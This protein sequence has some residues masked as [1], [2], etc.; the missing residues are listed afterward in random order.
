MRA[1]ASTE[2][3]RATETTYV[4]TQTAVQP[5]TP[6]QIC[7]DGMLSVARAAEFLGLGQTSIYRLMERGD[8]RWAN[9]LVRLRIPKR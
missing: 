6:E 4:K 9:V 2:P 8:L 1:V 3:K 7:N 5:E